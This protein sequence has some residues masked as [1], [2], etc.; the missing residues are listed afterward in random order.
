MKKLIISALLGLTTF[1]YANVNA[2]VSILPQKTFLK[3]IGGDKVNIS[4]MVLPGNSPHTYEPK[5][6][7]M[8]DIAKADIYFSI[9]VEFEHVWL[10]KFRSQNKNMK[11]VE[12]SKGITKQAIQKHSHEEERVHHDHG[13]EYK[14]GDHH[15]KHEALD[16]HIWTSPANVKLI[17]KNI[18]KALIKADKENANYYTKNYNN[19]IASVEKTDKTIKEILKDIPKD[20]KFMV[21]HPAWG[22]F[23]RDYHLTQFAIE[24]GGKNPKPKHIAFLIEE[25]K[26]EKVHAIFTAPEFSEKVATQIAKEVG[27]QVI[28]ISPLHPKWS[29]NLIKLA[30]A[31]ANR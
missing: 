19:F 4:L 2:V 27:V 29:Q 23:A 30:K 8:K 10:P 26:E 14:G 20:S 1:T 22:Y 28:K 31:I 16:P 13:D 21:F 7:Q 15:D 17:A 6:S 5:P 11:V 3:S 25:A 18:L 9:D 12:I 24:S